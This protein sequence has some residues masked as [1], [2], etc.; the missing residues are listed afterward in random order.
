MRVN[1][2]LWVKGFLRRCAVAGVPGV[3]V[4]RGD[5]EAGAIY[6]KVGRLDRTAALYGP[7][8]AGLDA[9]ARGSLFSCHLPDG[10]VEGEVDAAL[11]RQR[12]FDPDIWIVEIEDRAGRS[13]LDEWLAGD[14]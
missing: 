4:R 14:T 12:E 1:S 8:P 3:V 11:A 5:E 9:G 10:T 2:G 13:F 7:A 6:V